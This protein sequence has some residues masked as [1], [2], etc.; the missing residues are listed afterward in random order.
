MN[1]NYINPHQPGCPWHEITETTG[2]PNIKWCEQ[3]LC[4]WIS[5]P[6]N[7]WSNLG[8]LIV[9]LYI[10]FY[11]IQKQHNSQLKQFGPLVIFMGAMSF[12]YHMSNFYLTQILDFIGM[13]FF[14]GWILAINLLRLELIKKSQFVWFNLGLGICLTILL[15]AMYMLG[16]KFQVII[17]LAAIVI[18]I[19]EKLAAKKTKINY[20]W[21]FSALSLMAIAFTFSMVD[22]QRIWCDPS[23]HGW[24][25][26]GHALW[27][28]FGSFAMFA[29]YKHY[30]QLELR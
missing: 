6:A 1:I 2:A 24:F 3:T 30:S 29:I 22:G 16:L 19:T 12:F 20:N 8:Y 4:Q 11:S 9:G 13:F 26:Q 18:M 10:L 15:H 14:V 27:H 28:W 7:T 5:E 23:Q 17:L 25:S 21:L